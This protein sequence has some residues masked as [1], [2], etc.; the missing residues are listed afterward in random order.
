M[1]LGAEVAAE[2][3]TSVDRAVLEGY[4]LRWAVLAAWADQLRGRG[5]GFAPEVRQRQEEA[6]IKISSGCFANCE[7]G[8]ILSQI[9]AELMTAEGSAVDTRADFW[10]EL[11][12]M[13]MSNRAEAEQLLRIPAV[14]V[15]FSD[16]GVASC[17][18]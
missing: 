11:L 3:Q 16:C 1:N 14:K 5:M 7:V 18:C 8:C 13:A 9:E 10:T 6:R 4:G 12:A 17:R 15:H 2:R